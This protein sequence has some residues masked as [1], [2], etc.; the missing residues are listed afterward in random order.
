MS[1]PKYQIRRATLDDI[2]ELTKLWERMKFPVEDLARRI[3]EFQV[4]LDAQ[5]RLIGAV[6]LQLAQRQG[7]I[8]SEGFNDFG[9]SDHLRPLIWERLQAVGMNHGLLRLWT[10][11]EAPFWS[12]CGLE[13]AEADTLA[14]LP[15][16]WSGSPGQWL[17]LKLKE[18][19]EEILSAEKEFALFMES[20]KQRSQ[21]ALEHA[22]LLKMLATLLA[23]ALLILVAAGA[24]FVLKKNPQLLH[25]QG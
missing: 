4:A 22:K 14:K 18:D 13:R 15:A 23:V 12:R 10:R 2:G 11:E 21:R 25:R 19:I 9:L 7:L 1:S 6:G 3:T 8:H 5:G 17:T 24:I 16:I 20:E